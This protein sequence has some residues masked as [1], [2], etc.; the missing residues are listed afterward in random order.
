[1]PN[2]LPSQSRNPFSVYCLDVKFVAGCPTD[3]LSI[4]S[5][6]PWAS[7]YSQ[8]QDRLEIKCKALQLFYNVQDAL[9]PRDSEFKPLRGEEDWAEVVAAV[10]E[11]FGCCREVE[12]E[13]L[14][15]ASSRQLEFAARHSMTQAK[16]H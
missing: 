6:A 3:R 11:A 4:L 13:V 9:S 12:V 2:W 5:N 14:C 8:I 7:I 15:K 16:G 10:I 1:M